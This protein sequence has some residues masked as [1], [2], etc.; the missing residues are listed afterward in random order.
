MILIAG[1]GTGGH[2]FPGLAVA[3]AL[4]SLAD[5]EITFV[6]SP[7]GL[8]KDLVPRRG[9]ALELMDVAPLKGGSAWRA[10][11]G[12]FV[13]ARAT[14]QSIDLVGRL[15]PK[16]VMSVGGYAAGPVS[17]AAAMRGVPLAVLE[18]N[19]LMGF[20]N[21]ML[22]P[23]ARRMYVAW[24]EVA[25]NRPSARHVGVP[26]RAAFTPKKYVPGANKRVLV[27]GGSL[28]AAPINDRIPPALAKIGGLEVVHQTGRDRDR[29]V[30]ERY[31]RAKLHARVVPFLDDVAAEIEA[32]DLI[33]A[34]AGA[35]TIAEI[36]A[37]GR[38]ALFIPF[39]GAADDHQARNADALARAGGAICIRQDDAT[40]D[41]LASEIRSLLQDDERRIRMADRARQAGRPGAAMDIARDLLELARIP[42]GPPKTNGAHAQGAL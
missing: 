1:G 35:T 36:A 8:E 27:M 2:V 13:A 14:A 33:I 19:A 10:I 11:A 17:L 41:R 28:G 9:Y 26:I 37:I 31:E 25:G 5:V 16:A 30:R 15:A 3:D 18:P 6:G 21:R 39:P 7:R 22:A 12:A 24:P 4:R 40:E 20:T 42:L 23:F 32:A 34:R 29:R 38:A